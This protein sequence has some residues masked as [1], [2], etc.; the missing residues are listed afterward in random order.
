MDLAPLSP[1]FLH[2]R[3]RHHLNPFSD[4]MF[5][6]LWPACL[7]GNGLFIRSRYV[8]VWR[9]H[10]IDTQHPAISIQPIEES[11]YSFVQTSQNSGL[12]AAFGRGDLF[13]D[14]LGSNRWV[15]QGEL[16][17]SS[18]LTHN[19][20]F[21]SFDLLIEVFCPEQIVFWRIIAWE[22]LQ[23]WIARIYSWRLASRMSCLR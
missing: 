14:S 6:E 10:A 2:H 18:A 5:Y 13:L 7:E 3:H 23:N 15:L 1:T 21:I 9:W 4:V 19:S 20:R 22:L 12:R 16:L 17:L 8:A 11:W